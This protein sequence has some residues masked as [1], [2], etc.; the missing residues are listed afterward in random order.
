M[1]ILGAIIPELVPDD[2]YLLQYTKVSKDRQKKQ[3]W[4][5]WI[6]EKINV[7]LRVVK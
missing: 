2:L 6:D 5:G 7:V 4:G 3:L 1:I